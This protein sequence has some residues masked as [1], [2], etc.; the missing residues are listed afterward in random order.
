MTIGR[1]LLGLLT[2]GLLL[3]GCSLNR[4]TLGDDIKPEAIAAIQKGTTTNTEVLTLLGAPDRMF[5]LNGRDVWHY[6][7]YDAKMGALLAIA[8]NLSRTSVKSD[9]LYV[10]LNR[11]GKVDDILSSQRTEGL[12]FRFWPFGE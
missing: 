6:Y 5:Q 3:Q 7:R 9:D 8:L 12:T 2:V 11:D 1:C 10:I 4:A